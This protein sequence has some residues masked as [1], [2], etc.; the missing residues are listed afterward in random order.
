VW[1]VAEPVRHRRP[2]ADR[3]RI[4]DARRLHR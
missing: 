3:E 2:I 1:R 4:G